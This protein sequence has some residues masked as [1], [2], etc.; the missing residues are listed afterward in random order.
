MSKESSDLVDRHLG[1]VKGLMRKI[2]GSNGVLSGH[3]WA[4]EGPNN[5]PS[6]LVIT[7]SSKD[8]TGG[9][10]LSIGRKV[11]KELK[12]LGKKEPLFA[13]GNVVFEN[14]KI[15]FEIVNGRLTVPKLKKAFKD[16]MSDTVAQLRTVKVR[17]YAAAEEG[18]ESS[19]STICTC[20]RVCVCYRHGGGRR[21]ARA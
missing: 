21:I 4:A 15:V 10:V 5:A 7:L 1:E 13:R 18:A 11:K 12:T 6:A 19:G 8:K 9:K 17:M 2:A 14:G 3:F 20:A 16:E